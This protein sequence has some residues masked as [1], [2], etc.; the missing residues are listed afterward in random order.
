V[1][2]EAACV[3]LDDLIGDAGGPEADHA[4]ATP[5]ELGGATAP[6]A[7]ALLADANSGADPWGLGDHA[8]MDEWDDA[9]ALDLHSNL[10]DFLD[11]GHPLQVCLG[12]GSRPSSCS[13]PGDPWGALECI[14]AHQDPPDHIQQVIDATQ[15][16]VDGLSQAPPPPRGRAHIRPP[17]RQSQRPT[18][19]TIHSPRVR[20]R[21]FALLASGIR[22]ANSA[23]AGARFCNVHMVKGAASHE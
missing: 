5:S 7:L 8:A 6:D 1:C 13:C 20:C 18:L 14:L 21:C 4:D 22:C 16:L 15:A 9:A 23:K 12:C 17:A 10:E 19:H 3:D 11:Q 2:D